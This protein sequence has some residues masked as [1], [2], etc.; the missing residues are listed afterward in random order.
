MG[1]PSSAERNSIATQL[2]NWGF[3]NFELY[4][5]SAEKLEPIKVTGGTEDKCHI[6]TEDFSCV[7][8]KGNASKV[9]KLYEIPSKIAA[10]INNFDEIGRITYQCNG[11]IIGISSVRS[12]ETIEKI[13]FWGIFVR[14]LSK[15]LLK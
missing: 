7:V 10:P 1:A 3:A 11:E 4:Q 8:K 5:N 13:D 9:E 2:L 14:I 12:S 6:Y 15:I